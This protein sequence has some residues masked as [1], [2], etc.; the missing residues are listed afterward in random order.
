MLKFFKVTQNENEASTKKN[1]EIISA[2]DAIKSHMERSNTEASYEDS[3]YAINRAIK[4]YIAGESHFPQ[5]L[6]DK[7]GDRISKINPIAKQEADEKGYCFILDCDRDFEM[8]DLKKII[9]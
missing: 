1:S 4:H 8:I 5:W 2:D 9:S 6:Y 7:K 3:I